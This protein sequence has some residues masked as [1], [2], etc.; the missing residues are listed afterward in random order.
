MAYITG[1]ANDLAALRSALF[2][3]CIVNGWTLSGE[4]IRKGN[5][6]LRVQI[7]GNYL[8]FMGGTGIDGSNNLTGTAPSAARI[9]RPSTSSPDLVWPLS[10]EIFVLTNPDEVYLIC[11]YNVELYQWAAFGQSTMPGLSGTG[12]WCGASLGSS[13]LGGASPISITPTG[14]SSSSSSTLICPALFWSTGINGNSDVN[15]FIQH[16]LDGNAWSNSTYI[17]TGFRAAATLLNELPN[18]WN[19]ESVLV[20]IQVFVPRTSGNKMSML[21][22]LAHARYLRIDNHAPGEIITLGSDRWK[23]YPWYK[24]DSANR[25][26]GSSLTHS[27][28]MG[29]AVRYDGP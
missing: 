8:T 28:T 29:W 4:V 11:N 17:T 23:A 14:G 13:A 20:P 2:N 22:D 7:A 6:Y 3:A 10:Y 26:G 18:N 19:S 21:A 5:V 12:M 15:S 16:G 24:K 9:G 27:G 1:S 25:N